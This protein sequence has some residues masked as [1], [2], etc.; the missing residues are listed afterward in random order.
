MS[1]HLARKLDRFARLSLV[2]KE[3]LFTLTRRPLRNVARGQVIVREG[4]ASPGMRIFLSGWGYRCKSIEGGRRQILA[5]LLPGDV[6]DLNTYVLSHSDH[7][8]VAATQTTIVDIPHPT[9]EDIAYRHPAL[10]RALCWDE[11]VSV[12]LLREWIVNIGQRTALERM[13]NLFCELFVR[14]DL[15]GL[16]NE[17]SF[18]FP[19]TQTDLAAATGLSTVHV[20]RTLQEL[21]RAE[22][23]SLTGRGLHILDFP[24]LARLA[25]FRPNY[26]HLG[27]PDPATGAPVQQPV[28]PADRAPSPLPIGT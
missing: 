5:F 11:Q 14:L 15:V 8:I 9:V 3:A 12:S 16:V 18:A 1:S 22:L 21:R 28:G 13:A 24:R 20:N 2:E 4:E 19:I 17:S 27:Y 7:A 23:V 26:L 6:C 25:Q 10:F